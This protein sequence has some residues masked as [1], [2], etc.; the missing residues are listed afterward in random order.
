MNCAKNA[1]AREQADRD[2]GVAGW[3]YRKAKQVR[4]RD[5]SPPAR[6]WM[7]E[8]PPLRQARIWPSRCSPRAS[9][10]CPRAR[11]HNAMAS[12][13]M[14]R[15]SKTSP[16]FVSRIS[17]GNEGGGPPRR[18][19]DARVKED[20][21]GNWRVI[22]RFRPS[23]HASFSSP[24]E[25]GGRARNGKRPPTPEFSEGARASSLRQWDA[26]HRCDLSHLLSEVQGRGR[27]ENIAPRATVLICLCW[28]WV[29]GASLTCIDAGE[30]HREHAKRL[31]KRHTVFSAK[32][33]SPRPR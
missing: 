16:N 20:P 9:P 7:P 29:L 2:C 8:G 30:Q 23:P 14:M 1:R 6:H 33:P 15:S 24:M 17:L 21:L 18:E 5:G 31:R 25:F 11:A 26:G 3:R 13:R 27:S 10:V 19:A 32:V 12:A 28:R 22:S 4:G